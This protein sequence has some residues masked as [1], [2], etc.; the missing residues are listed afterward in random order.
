MRTFGKLILYGLISLVFIV[1]F[2]FRYINYYQAISI[3][4]IPFLIALMRGLKIGLGKRWY[5][6]FF[7]IT[8]T[9]LLSLNFGESIKFIFLFISITIL[10]DAAKNVSDYR[11]IMLKWFFRLSVLHT[12]VVLLQYLVPNNINPI[13][14]VTVTGEVAERAI[15]ANILGG[16]CTGFAGEA[17]F[18][19]LYTSITFFLGFLFYLVENKKTYLIFVILGLVCTFLTAK[20]IAIA[21]N[22]FAVLSCYALLV[23][24]KKIQRKNNLISLL[25]LLFVGVAVLNY[26][27]LADMFTQKNEILLESGDISNGRAELNAKMIQIF[28]DHMILG[29]GPYCTTQYTGEYLGH[30]IYLT[31]LSESGII[32]FVALIALLLLNFRDTMQRYRTGDDSMYMYVSLYIQLFFIIYG[33]TGNPLYD[34]QFL[35]TYILFAINES[36]NHYIPSCK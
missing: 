32:G 8:A 18:A 22:V 14:A 3:L 28:Q 35:T 25:F 5:F 23:K 29:I 36:R 4:S 24:S 1:S 9:G 26:T 7:A 13:I 6:Y 10:S 33:F 27:N 12:I 15:Q 21:I 34:T 30:N 16:V 20:R 17:S 31:T 19:M 11:D 2:F